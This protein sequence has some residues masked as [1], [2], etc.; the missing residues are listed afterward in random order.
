MTGKRKPS[1]NCHNFRSIEKAW[2]DEKVAI[3]ANHDELDQIQ[4]SERI[5]P[6]KNQYRQLRPVYWF[7]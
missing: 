3:I 4:N 1:K 5:S 7:Y 2:R 6:Q